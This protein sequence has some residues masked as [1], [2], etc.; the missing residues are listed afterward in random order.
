MWIKY[1]VVISLIVST[2]V[3][4][5]ACSN[6]LDQSENRI[7]KSDSSDDNDNDDDKDDDDN[8]KDD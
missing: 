7:E 5:S 6:P 3:W 1:L 8:D 4:L 2:P